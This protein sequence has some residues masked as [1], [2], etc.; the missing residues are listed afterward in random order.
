MTPS[1]REMIKGILRGENLLQRV[2]DSTPTIPSWVL[3]QYENLDELNRKEYNGK[4]K[5]RLN[6]S[7]KPVAIKPKTTDTTPKW[8]ADYE[9]Q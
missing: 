9:A 7:G 4:A 8:F 1:K 3:V 2:A 6:S 5:I